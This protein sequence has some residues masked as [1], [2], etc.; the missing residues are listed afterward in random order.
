[1]YTFVHYIVFFHTPEIILSAITWHV[2]DN[3]AIRPCQHEFVRGR[4]CLTNLISFYEQVTYL[5]DER[6]AADIV[7][8]DFS[9]ALDKVSRCISP[10][11]GGS[12]CLGQVQFCWVKN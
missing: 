5:V 2:Q 7:K 1:M 6:K 12:P 11:E 8:L 9:K 10:G 4:S 3:Q